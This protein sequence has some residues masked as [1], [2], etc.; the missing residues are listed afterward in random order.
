MTNT[1]EHHQDYLWIAI[2]DIHDDIEQLANIPELPTADGI[3]V[4]GDITL[5]G[6]VKQAER[7]MHAISQHSTVIF[8]QIGNMDREEITD[9]LATQNWNIHRAVRTIAPDVA[10]M[11]VGGSTFTPF[12]TPSEFPE[13]HFATWLEELWPL[14]KK[15]RKTILV[16]HNPPK[17]TLCDVLPNGVHVGSTAVREFIEEAQPDICIC[18]HIHEA[19]AIDRVGRTIVVNTG[20][21][22]TGGYAVIRLNKGILSTELQT[23]PL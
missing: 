19:K 15:S 20:P 16:S 12:G 17:D 11:G 7:V 3:I 6:G 5:G 22:A 8:A 13:S 23:L 2:G 9:W 4:T 10:I 1:A 18:G 14:A 21:L